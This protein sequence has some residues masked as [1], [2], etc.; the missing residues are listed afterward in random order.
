MVKWKEF[1]RKRSWPNLKVGL[2]CPV[3]H[4]EG[5]RKTTKTLRQDSRSSGQDWNPGPPEYESEMLT[6]WPDVRS[7]GSIILK[8]NL[9]KYGLSLWIG[10]N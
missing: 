10:F 6:T 8:W 1:G 5:L 2:L 3:T 9:Q 4:L 7:D